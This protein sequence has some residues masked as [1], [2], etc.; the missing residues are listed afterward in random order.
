[1]VK[2]AVCVVIVLPTMAMAAHSECGFSGADNGKVS[3]EYGGRADDDVEVSN[4]CGDSV[5]TMV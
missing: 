5:T 1:M 3:S 4:M 2:S